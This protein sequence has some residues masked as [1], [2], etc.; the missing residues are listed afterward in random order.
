M[1]VLIR[2]GLTST[3]KH[4]EKWFILPKIPSPEPD[5]SVQGTRTSRAM[6]FPLR[7]S[8]AE[9]AAPFPSRYMRT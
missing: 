8:R 9:P 6:A 3:Q 2:E 5:S 7:P 1:E 4:K